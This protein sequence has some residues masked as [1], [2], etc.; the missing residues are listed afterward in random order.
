MC[1]QE[2][3]GDKSP[4]GQT[5]FV[6]DVPIQIVGRL[7]YRGGSTG[8]GGD[9]DDRL[10]IPLTASLLLANG[11]RLLARNVPSHDESHQSLKPSSLRISVNASRSS[12]NS[13][14]SSA[15]LAASLLI[16]STAP[17]NFSGSSLKTEGNGNAVFHVNM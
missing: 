8:G 11:C 4:L 16:S 15:R 10:I 14:A 12:G 7:S 17:P 6:N 3:F 5:V 13:P 1:A 9:L 2:L